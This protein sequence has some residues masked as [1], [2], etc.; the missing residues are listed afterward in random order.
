MPQ[1]IL[2]L[3]T[4]GSTDANFLTGLVVR[5]CEDLFLQHNVYNMEVVEPFVVNAS[6]D[7]KGQVSQAERILQ[8]ARL[9]SGF[10]ALL[11]HS[12]AD[13]RTRAETIE[14]QFQPGYDEVNKQSSGVCE[15]LLPVIPVRMIEAWLLADT[16]TLCQ[17]LDTI[18]TPVQLGLPTSPAAIEGDA[19]PKQTLEEALRKVNANRPRTARVRRGEL[20]LPLGRS[21][22]LKEL[23][24]LNAYQEFIADLTAVLKQLNL[25]H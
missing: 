9:A 14:Y 24:R 19:N 16:Q 21:V 2:G 7:P 23:T 22:N 18:L 15:Q 6:L 25:I 3:Y 10:H 11:V 12:D 8:A 1:L 4:E 20:Y 17:E 13:K 5:A